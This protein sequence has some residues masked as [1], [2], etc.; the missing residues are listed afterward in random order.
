MQDFKLLG[1]L[2]AGRRM[3]LP[4]REVRR[5]V[6]LPLLETPASAPA[7]V[8]GFFDLAGTPVA[9]VRLDRLLNLGEGAPGIYSPL[10][11]LRS[12]DPPIALHVDTVTSVLKVSPGD[13]Q[14]IG[15]RETF[16]ACVV[17]R[18]SDSGETVYLLSAGDLLLAEE[19][20]RI[21]AISAIGMRR[22][23]ALGEH[24]PEVGHAG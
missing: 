15:R 16:N 20:E 13:V 12:S 19:R 22:M 18:V 11:V 24:A 2:A 4:L 7:F 17:G 21:A 9:A 5:V 8:E 10:L 14:P 1:F 6:P 23:A 3:A